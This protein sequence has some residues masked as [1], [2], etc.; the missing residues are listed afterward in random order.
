LCR[1]GIPILGIV[2][3]D[4][5]GL[6]QECELASG[7]TIF[8][9]KSDDEGG[10]RIFEHIFKCEPFYEGDFNTIKEMAIEVLKSDLVLI[11]NF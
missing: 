10:R 8:R 4:A 11:S 7:S 5:E 2:D 9:V 6:I 3:G 1:F